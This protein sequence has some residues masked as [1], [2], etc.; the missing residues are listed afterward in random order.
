MKVG[1]VPQVVTATLKTRLKKLLREGL[2]LLING[3]RKR[4][5][6]ITVGNNPSNTSIAVFQF[7]GDSPAASVGNQPGNELVIVLN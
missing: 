5:S 6:S 7:A 4:I 1:M 2:K 3:L